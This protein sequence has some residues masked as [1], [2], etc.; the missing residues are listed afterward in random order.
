MVLGWM[1]G[2]T[3]KGA[4]GVANCGIWLVGVRGVGAR[5]GWMGDLIIEL[6]VSPLD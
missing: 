4:L 6:S 1:G 2:D 3:G 5:H